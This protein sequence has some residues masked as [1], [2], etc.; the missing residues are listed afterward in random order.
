[1][2]QLGLGEDCTVLNA[3][4]HT[5]VDRAESE[6]AAARA[7]NATGPAAIAALCRESGARFAHVSTDYVFDGQ[8]TRPYREDDP[9]GPTTVYGRTKLEGEGLVLA[10]NPDAL[11]V[12]TSWVFGPGKNFVGA[13]LNQ[14][15]L[16]RCGEVQ[17]PLGVVDDQTGCPT[18][19]ADLAKGIRGLLDAGVTGLAHLCNS[20]AISWW[21]FARAILD[22]TG[23]D[24]LAI[25]RTRTVDNPRP[26]PRP[27]YSVLD[28]SRAA[29]S[30]V[31]LRPWREALVAYL[32]TPEGRA[33][34]EAA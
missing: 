6:R 13:I 14:A 24:S 22:E 29:S 4:A 2:V 28:C 25:D 11:I 9:T 27:A 32:E 18:Y 7:A 21:D 17:G 10:A 20:G 26:A 19:A 1:M 34:R 8:G 23:H 30:G 16:R 5:A 12:R 15:R 33:L 31:V 3:A